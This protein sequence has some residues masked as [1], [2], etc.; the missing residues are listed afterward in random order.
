MGKELKMKDCSKGHPDHDEEI[1]RLNRIAGQ[2]EGVKKMIEEGR[3]CVDI[4]TQLKAIQSATR[5]VECN[6]ME[7]H[8]G[9]CVRA[10]LAGGKARDVESKVAELIKLMKRS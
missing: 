3:Y 9:S 1:K 5:S 4:L 10:A 7:R 6:V 2:I 8:L